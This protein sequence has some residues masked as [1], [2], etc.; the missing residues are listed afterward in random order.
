[1]IMQQFEQV[2]SSKKFIVYSNIA[3]LLI[4]IISLGMVANLSKKYT[5]KVGFNDNADIV[6]S[7]NTQGKNEVVVVDNDSTISNQ[8]DT[9][10]NM[11]NAKN[12]MNDNKTKI[13][14]NQN[15]KNEKKEVKNDIRKENNSKKI[16]SKNEKKIS[17]VKVYPFTLQA[18]SFANE[19]LAKTSCENLIKNY[20]NKNG[21]CNVQK[22][23]NFFKVYFGNFESK[24]SAS[25]FASKLSKNNIASIVIKK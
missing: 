15:R 1:M 19:K 2:V 23:G 8:I 4:S 22:V 9:I 24:E 10:D 7:E 20:S 12:L 13:S 11:I 5:E 21:S 6:I 25:E 14:H 17:A 18:G 16:E 3:S